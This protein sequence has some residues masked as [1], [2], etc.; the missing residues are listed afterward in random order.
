M[1]KLKPDGFTRKKLFFYIF[2]ENFVFF[3]ERNCFLGGILQ[4]GYPTKDGIPF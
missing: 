1:M 3:R 4:K 2:N